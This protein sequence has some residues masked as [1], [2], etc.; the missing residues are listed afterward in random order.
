M[1]IDHIVPRSEG[2]LS[3][4]E[5]ALA[6][7]FDCHAEIHHYNVKHPRGRRFTPEEL[8]DHRDQWLAI[9]RDKPGALTR[10]RDVRVGP[11]QA[12][13]DELDYNAAV[14]ERYRLPKEPLGAA[15][16]VRQFHRAIAAGAIAVL[17]EE[18]KGKIYTAYAAADAANQQL[19]RDHAAVIQNPSFVTL[20][21]QHTHTVMADA[22]PL[23]RTARDLLLRF[24]AAEE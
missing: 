9:C 23:M 6:V 13:I 4:I 2:G 8:R 22:A 5:N 11:L 14:A 21:N 12:M 16:A 24:A 19:G 17:D 10:G 1:E 7:C 20:H 15:L 18:L 3:T